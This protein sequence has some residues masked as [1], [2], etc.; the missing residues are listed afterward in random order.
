MAFTAGLNQSATPGRSTFVLNTVK[1]SRDHVEE[2]KIRV[3]DFTRSVNHCQVVMAYRQDWLGDFNIDWV[4]LSYLIK[5]FFLI[6]HLPME[7]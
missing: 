5:Q 3:R 4:Q 2:N 7:A 6:C 1:V